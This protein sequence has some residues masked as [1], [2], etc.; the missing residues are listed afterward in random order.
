M[1]HDDAMTHA[2]GI[3][4]V[5]S[6]DNATTGYVVSPYY[7]EAYPNDVTCMWLIEVDEGN[8]IELS[9]MT[10]DLQPRYLF[11]SISRFIDFNYFAYLKDIIFDA[12]FFFI[13]ARIIFISMTVIISMHPL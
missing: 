12:Y 10:F 2:C 7:P 6:I 13:I 8:I 1:V 3:D 4:K 11:L 9:F 5:Y